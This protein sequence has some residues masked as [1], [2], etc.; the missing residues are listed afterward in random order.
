MPE[1]GNFPSQ[2]SIVPVMKKGLLPTKI[3]MFCKR[4]FEWRK[5]WANNWDNV[6]YCSQRCRRNKLMSEVKPV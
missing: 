1:L 2:Y 3:C 6:K 5:K 4:P